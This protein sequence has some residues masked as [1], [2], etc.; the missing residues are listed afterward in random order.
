[1]S[2]F[3]TVHELL[4]LR[5]NETPAEVAIEAPDRHP[6]NYK[7]LLTLV[8]EAARVFSGC[9]IGRND[10]VAI[11]LPNGPEMATAFLA[12]S[13]VASSAPLNPAY[14]GQ[15]FEF[16]LSDLN[17]KA[18][19]VQAGSETPAREAAHKLNIPVIELS[20]EAEKPAG[21][22]SLSASDLE[23]E[24]PVGYAESEDEAL[25]LHTSGTTSR[26]KIVPLTQK[27][28][29]ASAINISETLLLSPDDRCLNVM[30]LFHIHGLMAAV[31]A[32]IRSA[33]SVVCTPGFQADQFFPWLAAFKPSW[34]TAVPTMH[35]TILGLLEKNPE[36]AADSSLRFLRS[37]S[38]SL[39]PV[40]MKGLE[41]AFQ[42]PMIE[43]YGMTEAAHQMACNPLPPAERKAGTVGV[44][45][46]PEVQI[47]DVDGNLL[48]QGERGEIV[49]RGDNVTTGYEKNPEAN[50]ASFTNGWF[51]TG[52]EGE[53]D[54]AGY[55]T[56]T[57]RLKE[58][59]N[60]GGEKIAPREVDEAL[61]EHAEVKQAVAFAVPHPTLGEDLAAAVVLTD[62]SSLT[63]E[64]LR[65]F[66]FEQLADF[67][68]PSQIVMVDTIPKGPTGKLQRIGLA[69]ALSAELASDYVAP[70]NELEEGLIDIWQRV[71]GRERVGIEDNF[72]A[73]GGDSLLAA[74]VLRETVE[75]VGR[76]LELPILFQAPTIAQIARRLQ[77]EEQEDE[78]VI[79]MRSEGSKVPLF[80]VPGHGGDIFTYSHLVKYLDSDR[81]VYV[82]R[83]PEK[84][85][86]DDEVANRMIRDMASMYI[87][88]MK[89]LQ[90]NGPYHVAG[91]CFGGEVAF[92][93]AQ[94]LRK[95][96]SETGF[97]GIMF[98]Y[99]Q[100]AV[101]AEG[102]KERLSFHLEQ[103]SQGGLKD[104]VSYVGL[105]F[106]RILERGSRRMQTTLAAERIDAKT[107]AMSP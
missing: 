30:P 58:M 44:E 62:G 10:R 78:Y 99:L 90:P 103:F 93:I 37:S 100:G 14:R 73:L 24:L 66:A 83:F 12:V 79:G 87:D 50:E 25:V 9:A 4:V 3:K 8:E 51:R 38:A 72:F 60:R 84:A 40:V 33:A 41:D 70:T 81:P 18:L 17:A 48:P 35:Q 86:V 26:P 32:S 49:I 76:D 80:L 89:R 16:Y 107:A 98:V 54:E 52:D 101:H 64:S 29:C 68:V 105:V 61:L 5:A 74:T 23:S 97:V 42:A 13:S 39:P 27:N 94:Q 7:A 75:L 69:D 95:R 6:L 102:W 21:E 46:G 45:A 1:M 106:R 53:L 20:I 65:K 96:E 82:F 88:E 11:V 22:F 91:F 92:E 31:L 34:Y 67:K 56:I 15:E 19:L 59:V 71:L 36:L 77:G 47:M 43:A 85:R 63:E 2:S 104:K 57:G 28:I 55:L